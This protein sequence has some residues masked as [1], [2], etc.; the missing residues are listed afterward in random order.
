MSARHGQ[1]VLVTGA[2]GLLGAGVA[3]RLVAEGAD[4]V[5]LQRRPAA[6]PG[7]R[8]VTGSVTDPEAVARAMAGR[9]T[10]VHVAAKVSVSGPAEDYEQVNVAGTALV[11]E[12]ARR[13][14]VERFVHLSSPS[15]A[16]AGTSIVGD[17]AGPADPA[18]ARGHYARTKAAGELLALAA[19]AEDLRVLVLR[20]HLMWGPGDTQLTERIIERARAGRMPLLGPSAALIDSLYTQNAV[21]AVVAAV[22]AVDRVHGEALVVTNGEPR[23]VG[24][25]VRGL[26]RAGGAPEPRLRIPAGPARAAGGVIERLWEAGGFGRGGDEPPLTRFLAEQLSTAH[27]FDQRRTREALGWTPA[28]SIDRGLELLAAHYST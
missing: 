15:V 20:P 9:N 12:A 16:H 27:W 26:S 2:S 5:T 23:P 8:D 13:A 22:D 24:E 10:V 4:V 1:R 19:D 3:R 25:L 28:V 17:G 18:R 6:V 11:L 21:D 7:A 14:G